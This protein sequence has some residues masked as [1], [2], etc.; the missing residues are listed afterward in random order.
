MIS[1]E[2]HCAAAY[3]TKEGDPKVNPLQLRV[4]V[5]KESEKDE[6]DGDDEYEYSNG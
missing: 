5:T 6:Q 1:L 4:F 2:A 3:K